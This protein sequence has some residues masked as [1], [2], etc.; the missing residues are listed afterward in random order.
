MNLSWLPPLP[1]LKRAD[2]L[3]IIGVLGPI[4]L[5]WVLLVGFDAFLQFARQLSNLGRNGYTLGQ[6]AYFIML[7]IPRRFFEMYGNAALIGTL[8]GLGGLAA[9]NELTALRASGMSRLRIGG[10]ALALVALLSVA[11]L[12]DA[13]YVMPPAEAR[14]QGIQLALTARNIA[15]ATGTGLWAR[16]GDS[17][18]NVRSALATHQV[19]GRGIDL[20][21]VRIYQFDAQGRLLSIRWAAAANYR[22]GRWQ[23]E[24]LQQTRF[25]AGGAT[26][27]VLPTAPWKTG[28]SPRLLE[29]SVLSPN[30]Q[31]ISDLLRNI[32][33]LH[34]N[35][36]DARV[37]TDALWQ[38]LFY[39][40]NVL[41]LVLCTLPLTFGTLRAGGFGKRLLIGLLIA[42]GWFFLQRAL[43]NLAIVYSVPA[44]LANLGP[45]L[46]LAMVAIWVFRRRHA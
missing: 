44:W 35:G 22:D 37:Y 6:A 26:R 2:K 16:D 23:L 19:M 42:V 25:G 18:V 31:A 40:L 15:A 7:T 11:A 28:L 33:Y 10:A 43:V 8:L 34:G 45:I 46:L 4:V 13:E 3:L 12:L 39:P 20:R 41:M 27:S 9:S 14:A 32:D 30:T 21:D 5:T 38:R 17:I 24:Q 36:L 29:L 1:R